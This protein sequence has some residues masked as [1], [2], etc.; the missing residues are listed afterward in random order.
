MRTYDPH[1][2]TTEVRQGNRR[3]MNMRVL[4]FSGIA[5]VIAFAVIFLVFQ[6][7]PSGNTIQ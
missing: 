2:D 6:I 5:I 3:L 4:L 1:K 7:M